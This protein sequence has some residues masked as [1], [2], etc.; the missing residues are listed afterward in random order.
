[1]KL[2]S[3][4]PDPLAIWEEAPETARLRMFEIG[5]VTGGRYFAWDELRHRRPPD[6]LTVEQ[7]WAGMRLA[8][9]QVARQVP[10]EP[11]GW[12][13]F[14]YSLVEPVLE[15]LHLMDQ[16]AAGRLSV[17]A[18]ILDPTTRDRYVIN[19]LIEEAIASSQ[20]EGALSTRAVARE[21]IRQGRTPRNESEQMILNNYSAIRYIGE[22]KSGELSEEV[23]LTLHRILTEGTMD[24]SHV[25]R[26]QQPNEERVVVTDVRD[27]TTV[28]I[29]PP[30]T[31]IPQRM[32]A[33]YEFAN[34]SE[35]GFVH[36][37]VRA[38]G[39]H[40]WLAHD[41][42]FFD[43]NGRT[44]RA[45][46]YW[47]ALRAGYWLTEFVSI[48]SVI[49]RAPIRYGRAFVLSERDR[50]DMTYFLVH[51]LAVLEDA[52]D[53]VWAYV[54]Q[55]QA[56][57]LAAERLL[58]ALPSVNH[59]QRA[60]IGHALRK[61]GFRYT[62]QSHATS[63]GVTR[64]TA[65]TDLLALAGIGLLDPARQGRRAEFVAP[66]DLSWRLKSKSEK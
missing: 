38:I 18:P 61:P 31:E 53:A 44:A 8:R 28:H 22:V 46:F 20:I 24:D 25:G 7:W 35:E 47:S 50:N 17:P 40:Y 58:R 6:G 26:F 3:V 63:H 42:P 14:T 48:S 60:L 34:G 54:E 62:Y 59:R 9:S 30:A 16:Q 4:P 43:G 5:P 51:Q 33:L 64:Q 32:E 19:G 27:G 12:P 1:M 13:S 36:P 2:P 23:V 29:P 15:K 56:E 37:L 41:H 11:T 39:L 52:F 49:L 66:G 21:M 65:R 10:S 57:Y 45:L 55:K